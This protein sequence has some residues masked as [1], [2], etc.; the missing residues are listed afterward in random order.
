MYSNVRFKPISMYCVVRRF[1]GP[2]EGVYKTRYMFTGV[3]NMEEHNNMS[4]N[5]T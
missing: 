3:F 4:N 1:L 5:F 2:K